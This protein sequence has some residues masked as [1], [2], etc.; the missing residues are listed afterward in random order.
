MSS[1]S[2]NQGRGESSWKESQKEVTDGISAHGEET[3]S[4]K[5]A[6]WACTVQHRGQTYIGKCTKTEAWLGSG[7]KQTFVTVTFG[8]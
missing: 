8:R 1:G 4:N 7:G 2:W 3:E 6:V 5:G